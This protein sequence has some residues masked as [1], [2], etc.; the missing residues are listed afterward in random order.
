M[1]LFKN[2]KYPVAETLYRNGFYVPSG[3]SLN[4]YK[5]S[6]VSRALFKIIN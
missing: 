6:N 4:K 1:G 5:I 3:L 2:E